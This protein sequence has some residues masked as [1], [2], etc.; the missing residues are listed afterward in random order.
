M[1]KK[2]RFRESGG[3]SEELKTRTEEAVGGN[4]ITIF[5]KGGNLP[6]WKDVEGTML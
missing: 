1:A 6:F 2:S 3:Y 4:Y 5:K